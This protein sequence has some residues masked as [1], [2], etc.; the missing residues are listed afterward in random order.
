MKC[1]TIGHP[2]SAPILSLPSH[3]IPHPPIISPSLAFFTEGSLA[4]ISVSLAPNQQ[5]S[6]VANPSYS[7]APIAIT[8]TTTPTRQL[9]NTFSL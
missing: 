6:Y 5:Q 3:S 8:T 9:A 4:P 7:R 1:F 2:S